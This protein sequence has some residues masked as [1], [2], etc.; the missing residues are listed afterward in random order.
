MKDNLIDHVS[1]LLRYVMAF[2]TQLSNYIPRPEFTTAIQNLGDRITAVRANLSDKFLML[3]G[4][5]T[6]LKGE[7]RV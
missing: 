1:A 7:L 4:K 2:V 3:V 6:G 5:L